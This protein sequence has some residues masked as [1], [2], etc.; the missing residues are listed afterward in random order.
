MWKSGPRSP[1]LWP[2][3]HA[4]LF[5]LMKALAGVEALSHGVLPAVNFILHIL[6]RQPVED[7]LFVFDIGLS[8]SWCY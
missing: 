4:G 8:A 7:A 2:F 5:F 1:H 6:K 3:C